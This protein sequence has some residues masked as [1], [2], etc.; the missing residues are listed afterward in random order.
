MKLVG[1]ARFRLISTFVDKHLRIP[2]L[3]IG[4][5]L[6][7]LLLCF[8]EEMPIFEHIHSKHS[9]MLCIWHLKNTPFIIHHGHGRILMIACCLVL[10]TPGGGWI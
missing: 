9:F 6:Q 4:I 1:T 3:V 8:C 10:C 5:G 7:L 2:Y